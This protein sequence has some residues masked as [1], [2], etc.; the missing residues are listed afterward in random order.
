M[1]A[2]RYLTKSDK[3]SNQKY[4]DEFGEEDAC[5]ADDCSDH[6]SDVV[7]RDNEIDWKATKRRLSMTLT[8][9]KM[10]AAAAERGVKMAEVAAEFE[11]AYLED[12]SAHGVMAPTIDPHATHHI[13]EMIDL[14][15]KLI[16][17]GNAYAAD[18]HVLF[19]VPSCGIRRTVPPQPG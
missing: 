19:N 4:D 16:A 13:Q 7:A 1:T 10:M 11:A 18:G 12:M 3:K 15:E 5:K 9:D 17:A 14:A 8:K 2:N 6:A